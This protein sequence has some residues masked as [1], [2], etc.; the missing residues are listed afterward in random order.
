MH[1]LIIKALIQI[2]KNQCCIMDHIDRLGCPVPPDEKET[3][4]TGS[5]KL[6]RSLEEKWPTIKD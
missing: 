5:S 3:L 1:R 4:K 6:V 2:L